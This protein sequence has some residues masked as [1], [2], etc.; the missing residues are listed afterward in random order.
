MAPTLVFRSSVTQN[1]TPPPPRPVRLHSQDPMN[2]SSK[3]V[4]PILSVTKEFPSLI[5]CLDLPGPRLTKPPSVTISRL[6]LLSLDLTLIVSSFFSSPFSDFLPLLEDFPETL[7]SKLFV[8]DHFEKKIH[9]RRN[10]E[11][12]ISLVAGLG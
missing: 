2:T 7:T 10:D 5:S 6:I 3:M 11:A 1:S 9:I 8:M 4:L 12:G